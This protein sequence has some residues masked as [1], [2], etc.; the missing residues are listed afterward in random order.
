M[1]NREVPGGQ[2]IRVS[3]LIVQASIVLCV[4]REKQR[5]VRIEAVIQPPVVSPI[6]I[7]SR[8]H[9]GRLGT[10]RLRERQAQQCFSRQ[11]NSRV[12][13]LAFERKKEKILVFPDW[14]TDVAT[15]LLPLELRRRGARSLFSKK[16]VG[17]Q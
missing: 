11:R 12:L 9:G 3:G 16:V 10:D 4:V 14:P 2:V 8:N 7:R 15:E 1:V 17:V 5:F 13:P 6:E